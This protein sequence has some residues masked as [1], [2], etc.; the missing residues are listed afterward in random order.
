MEGWHPSVD[1]LARYLDGEC[2]PDISEEVRDHLSKCTFCSEL[3]EP[4]LER[5][6]VQREMLDLRIMLDEFGITVR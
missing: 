6:R 2:E 1:C 5:R 4:I 3:I